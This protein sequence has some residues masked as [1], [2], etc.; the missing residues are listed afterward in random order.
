MY[1]SQQG[2]CFVPYGGVSAPYAG[3]KGATAHTTKTKHPPC[4]WWVFIE[5]G[6]FGIAVSLPV[7]R[8]LVSGAISNLGVL[9]KSQIKSGD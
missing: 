8:S 6:G 1:T 9:C 4:L 5:G 7:Y 3:A 2:E